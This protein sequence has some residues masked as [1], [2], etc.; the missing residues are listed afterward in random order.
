MPVG[1][2]RCA[3]RQSAGEPGEIGRLLERRIDQDDA[4]A[5]LGR[6]IGAERGPAVE[7]QYLGAAV[8]QHAFERR[9]RARLELAGDQPVLRPHQG[10]RDERRARI[11]PQ[12]AVGIEV[13]HDVEIRR[14]QRPHLVRQ[15]PAQKSADTVLPLAAAGRFSAAQIVTAG[16][17]M[18]V[19]HAERRRLGF[20]IGQ[21]ARQHR[22][23]V[24]VGEIAGMECVL[25]IH[26]SWGMIFSEN[27]LPP[28]DQVRG[29]AF[30]DD[31]QPPR[32]GGI[33]I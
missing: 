13:L 8:A 30:R 33:T 5:L 31:A 32:T 25:I 11:G 28:S 22:V 1:H 18:G 20:Q 4:A 12:P 19:D 7:R 14:E 29:Q 6:H 24:H 23:L 21:D 17:R 27:R 16:A 10:K 9:R 26:V 2:L 15:R 3:R